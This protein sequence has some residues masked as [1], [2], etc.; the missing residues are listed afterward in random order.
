MTYNHSQTL[1]SSVSLKQTPSTIA[2]LPTSCDDKA[3]M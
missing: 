1:S 2:F 3:D